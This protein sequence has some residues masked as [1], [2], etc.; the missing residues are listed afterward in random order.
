MAPG[1]T[2]VS[3]MALATHT[4]PYCTAWGYLGLL[5]VCGLGHLFKVC[6]LHGAINF[7][8]VA[9]GVGPSTQSVW[10]GAISTKLCGLGPSTE[11]VWPGAINLKT[12]SVWAGAI[13]VSGMWPGAI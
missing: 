11:T 1:H 7:R 2:P 8:C 12:F 5:K 10:S 9:W 4:S 6:G 13:Y 3:W